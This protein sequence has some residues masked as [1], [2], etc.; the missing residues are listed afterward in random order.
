MSVIPLCCNR[1]FDPHWASQCVR[2]ANCGLLQCLFHVYIGPL[3]EWHC[4]SCFRL[5]T[6][7][8]RP[9]P[10]HLKGGAQNVDGPSAH[11]V[12]VFHGLHICGAARHCIEL[13]STL[14]R[15]NAFT[16]VVSLLGGGHWA[17]LFLNTSNELMILFDPSVTGRELTTIGWRA[18]RRI[19]SAHYDLSI[20]WALAAPFDCELFAHFHTEPEFSLYTRS[21]LVR[22]GERSRR[23]FFPSETTRTSYA[24]LLTEIPN[25][26]NDVT[27]IMPNAS[28]ES[29]SIS[30]TAP[31]R[32]P[33]ELRI[34]IVSR[35]DSDKI[36]PTLLVDTIS[37][38]RQ[39][40]RRLKVKVAGYGTIGDEVERLV[41]EHGLQR[42]VELIGWTTDIAALYSWSNV[43]FLPSVSETMPYAAIESVESGRPV[44]VPRYGHFSRTEHLPSLV[45]TYKGGSAR[46]AVR[47]IL[48]AV[49][50]RSPSTRPS[51]FDR[52]SWEA[53]VLQAYGFS[54]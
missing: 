41:A 36:S 18:K 35:L 15:A 3:N 4:Y 38:V 50:S 6:R 7:L 24:Q 23:I 19:V 22:A 40:V 26:W 9:K 21:T 33:G 12:V 1:V 11:V 17:D 30:G 46:D 2:C 52:A 54:T 29:A 31:I 45:Y 48:S 53:R 32:S 5:L 8:P 14:G 34:G 43:T 16:T 20:D 42:D 47:A 28:P 25:W 10:L 13:L 27:A 51:P 37:L 39:Q 44:V 49:N